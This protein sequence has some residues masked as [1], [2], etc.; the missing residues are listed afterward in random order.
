MRLSMAVTTIRYGGVLVFV[1]VCTVQL[2][3][4]RPTLGES[5]KYFAMA[6]AA[7]VGRSVI[8]IMNVERTVWFMT[9]EA[10]FKDHKAGVAAMKFFFVVTGEAPINDFVF[11]RM[12]KCAVL[13]GMFTWEG[14]KFFAFF[15][16]TGEAYFHAG[17]RVLN[18]YI[19]WGMRVAMAS[20]TDRTVANPE[21]FLIAGV[22]AH[23]TLGNCFASQGKMLNMAIETADGS[24]VLSAVSENVG[25]LTV[26]A[27]CTVGILQFCGTLGFKENLL[28]RRKYFA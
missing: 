19:Q 24:F 4:F 13:L 3:V 27:F 28:F 15:S 14:S 7:E 16:M 8:G 2:M 22:M 23:G 9:P 12:A 5:L 25:R 17:G 1:T 18:G 20:D 10:V 26:M 11:V 21:M 6:G